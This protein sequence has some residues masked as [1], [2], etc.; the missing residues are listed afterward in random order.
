MKRPLAAIL[1]VYAP[2]L[3]EEHVAR[4]DDEPWMATA[5]RPFAASSPEHAAYL[6]FQVM[7][8][9][10]LAALLAWSVGGRPRRA[11]VALLGLALVAEAHHLIRFVATG[12]YNAGLFTALPMPAIGALVLATLTSSKES[13]P[14]CS[15][16]SSSAWGSDESSSA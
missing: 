13:L 10:G 2:H 8:A 15:S 3:I 9:V 7:L 12:R 4:V 11:V 5:L 1:A 6:V 14:S 16:T